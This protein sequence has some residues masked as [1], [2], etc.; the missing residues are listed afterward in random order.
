MSSV[1]VR[2][3]LESDWKTLKN[4]RLKALQDSP[5]AF[6]VTYEKTKTHSDSEWQDRAA[7]RTP[8]HYLLAFDVED[9]IGMVGGIV[10]EQN[11][12]NVVAMWVRAKF[13][14]RSIAE[15]MIT[16]IKQYAISQG[17]EKIVL[18]VSWGHLR[19]FQFYTKLGFVRVTEKDLDNS[20][21]GLNSQKMEC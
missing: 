14:S 21:F 15:Q 12:F 9:A 13:Y 16:K 20:N 17:F 18:R 5:D 2:P 8:C 1:T 10:D 3:T 4:L 6:K 19:A 7:Q 11:E